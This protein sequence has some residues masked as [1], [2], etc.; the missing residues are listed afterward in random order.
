M[1]IIRDIKD[2]IRRESILDKFARKMK[3]AQRDA[4]H[5][6]YATELIRPMEISPEE[7]FWL[8]RAGWT[9]RHDL[10]LRFEQ[11]YATD[12]AI[13][14]V[15]L[16]G[17]YGKPELD[18][19]HLAALWEAIR[20]TVRDFG[21]SDPEQANGGADNPSKEAN[22]EVS[23]PVAV[24]VQRLNAGPGD[25]SAVKGEVIVPERLDALAFNP[26]KPH[27]LVGNAGLIATEDEAFVRGANPPEQ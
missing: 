11:N 5:D 2:G 18:R 12:S 13:F 14:T 1:G 27:E 7:A 24:G 9:I 6:S 22:D 19:R 3:A 4:Q 23:A 16:F 20:K 26:A 15:S 8:G 17:E 25:A 21:L 10:S